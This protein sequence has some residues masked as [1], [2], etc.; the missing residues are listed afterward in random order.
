MKKQTEIF[1]SPILFKFVL[2]FFGLKTLFEN[3]YLHFEDIKEDEI[4]KEVREVWVFGIAD[5]T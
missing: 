3:L 5:P 1:L 2:G 4:I